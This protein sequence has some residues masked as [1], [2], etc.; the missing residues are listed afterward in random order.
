MPQQRVGGE[1]RIAEPE[2][3]P[4]EQAGAGD[5]R[6]PQTAGKSDPRP[7]L[8]DDRVQAVGRAALGG[9]Y[10]LDLSKLA[11]LARHFPEKQPWLLGRTL[12]G[13]PVPGVDER[14]GLARYIAREVV[15]EPDNS[16]PAGYAGE[17]YVN[18]GFLG[19]GLGFLLLGAFHRLAFNYLAERALSL[20]A[21]AFLIVLIPISTVLLLNSGILPAAARCAIDFSILLLLLS[22]RSG[23]PRV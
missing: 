15:L 19:L 4:E 17:L 13:L 23:V 2:S 7:L 10:L 12:V 11:H 6:S 5:R 22:P 16:V 21:A 18:F 14:L 9:R 8:A 1:S 20:P 3:A